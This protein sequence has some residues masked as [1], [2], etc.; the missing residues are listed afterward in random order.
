MFREGFAVVIDGHTDIGEWVF[1]STNGR[2]EWVHGSGVSN[3]RFGLIDKSGNIVLP[4]GEY[5]EILCVSEGHA[6]V[7]KGGRLGIARVGNVPVTAPTP[8]AQPVTPQPTAPPAASSASEIKVVLNGN[9]LSFDVS[10]RMVNGR[11]LI[12]MRAIFEALGATVDWNRDTQTVN[13]VKDGITVS[14]QIGSYDLVRNGHNFTLDV[15]AQ[16]IDGRTFVPIRAIAEAFG[17][18]VVWD[19][20]TQTVIITN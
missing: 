4:I 16:I 3:E 18:D 19:G 9:L 6:V 5:S 7:R 2:Y 10:P 1:S 13:A 15:P 17:V 20:S 11:T 8:S 14:L 12:P